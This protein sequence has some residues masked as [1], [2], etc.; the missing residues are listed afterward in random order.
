MLKETLYYYYMSN[1]K[2]V[3]SGTKWYCREHA[4]QRKSE[5][6]ADTVIEEQT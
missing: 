5:A 1:N 4:D 6:D 2:I 3:T